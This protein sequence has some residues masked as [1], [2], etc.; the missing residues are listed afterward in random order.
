MVWPMSACVAGSRF[1]SPLN[2][3]PFVCFLCVALCATAAGV[4]F[5]EPAKRLNSAGAMHPKGK[6]VDPLSR[7]RL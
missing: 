7:L 3:I 4:A 6:S 2:P 5:N 1:N